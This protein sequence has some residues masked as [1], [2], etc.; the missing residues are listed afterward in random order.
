MWVRRPRAAWS[1]R[2]PGRSSTAAT[3][4]RSRLG[5]CLR[6]PASAP[7]SGRC[8]LVAA[9]TKVVEFDRITRFSDGREKSLLRM[10]ETGG[11]FSQ[12]AVAVICVACATGVWAKT[13]PDKRDE[14]L[15]Y[16]RLGQLQME[17]GKTLKAIESVDK[18]L[19]LDPENSEAHYLLGF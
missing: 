10:R 15:R 4:K 8:S 16:Y 3:W 19:K 18:A 14:A 9:F 11:K 2:R 6:R 12:A 7:A 17:Q 13:S 5:P 1:R